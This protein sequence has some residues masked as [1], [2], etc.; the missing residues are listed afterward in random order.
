MGGNL[1]ARPR[2][3]L[4]A[5]AAVAVGIACAVV[6]LGF[7]P[8][9]TRLSVDDPARRPGLFSNQNPERPGY[10]P[11]WRESLSEA[12]RRAPFPILL[13][14]HA[15]A[16]ANNLRETYLGSGAALAYLIFPPPAE[17][18]LPVRQEY[19]QIIIGLW[20]GGDAETE[21]RE[22]AVKAIAAGYDDEYTEIRGYP[23][24]MV[25]PNAESDVDQANPAF[26]RFVVGNFEIQVNGGDD[27]PRVLE[28]AEDLADK[29]SRR[30]G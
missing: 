5:V 12:R 15:A 23:A 30:S 22:Y 8:G 3:L 14:E 27:L 20:R 21:Y 13:P 10:P 6:W 1:L 17:P 11:E 7:D 28:I 19:L 18:R 29:Y 9:A 16:N 24:L 26:V 2:M 4:V 25:R